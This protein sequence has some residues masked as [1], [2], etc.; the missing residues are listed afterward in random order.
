MKLNLYRTSHFHL[1]S[2]CRYHRHRPRP[3]SL[4][5]L[6]P[7]RSDFPLSLSG[8]FFPLFFLPSRSLPSLLF[9][10]SFFF[11]SLLLF[12]PLPTSIYILLAY[13]KQRRFFHFFFQLL[14]FRM[15]TYLQLFCPI[16]TSDSHGNKFER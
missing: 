9:S 16:L 7:L 8:T 15:E 4:S 6:T 10:F 14:Q 2:S 13:S 1:P 11:S 3:S 12:F 5:L